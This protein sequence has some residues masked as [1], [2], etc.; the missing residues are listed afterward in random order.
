MGK[1]KDKIYESK[2]TKYLRSTVWTAIILSFFVPLIFDLQA[3]FPFAAPR[4]FF[5]MAMAQVAFFAWIVL[6]IKNKR[7]RPKIDLVTG[8]VGA[9]FIVLVLS[10]ILGADPFHSFWS[11][12]ERM[13]GLLTY[14]HLFAF[15]LV[16]SSIIKGEKDWMRLI[17]WITSIASIVSLISIAHRFGII[18]LSHYFQ[19]GSTLGNT[20]FMGS[21]LLV[22]IFFCLYAFF[23]SRDAWKI[24]YGTSFVIISSAI[25]LNPGGRAMKGALLAGTFLLFLLYFA[26]T[27]RSKIIQWA[28]RLLIISGI[29]L[30]L[31]IS[32]FAFVE[33]SIVREKIEDLRGMSARFVVWDIAWEGFKE[34]PVLGWGLENFPLVFQKE[35]NPELVVLDG[36]EVWFDRAHNIVFDSLVT[37]GLLGTLF[38]FLMFKA[39]LFV[40]WREY[41]KGKTDIWAPAIFTSLFVA[42]FIQNLTVFDMIS[43]FM[44]M[45]VMLAF[46]AS[47]KPKNEPSDN[48]ES[49]MRII[50]PGIFIIIT[51]ITLELFVLSSYRAN[52]SASLVLRA[53][54]EMTIDRYQEALKDPINKDATI[55]SISEKLIM[56]TTKDKLEGE[57]REATIEKMRFIIDKLEKNIASPPKIFKNYWI[58]GRMYNEYYNYRFLQELIKGD[59]SNKEEARE[60]VV[61]A[62]EILTM[63][64]EISPRRPEGYWELAQAKVNMGNIH[65]LFGE[66]D[67]AKERFNESFILVE[68]AV[69]LEPRDI[70]SQL[71][72]L[73]V[74]DEIIM[75]SELVKRKANEALEINPEWEEILKR[76]LDE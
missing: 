55:F 39:A 41:W 33:G 64:I 32:V 71:K 12:Y 14:I 13:S 16:L 54:V 26:F 53:P 23:K 68:K 9:F 75:D 2:G 74:A 69:A 59:F 7:Y 22:A 30:T 3:L 43:S 19:N 57:E 45:F 67:L 37:I 48:S 6:A 62:K 35:F 70:R 20:S 46:A 8:A 49:S 34:R 1:K 73:K 58:T 42:Y 65:I 63:A 25:L 18:E 24:F 72:M 52:L 31:F 28:A 50:I 4:A 17:G 38:F 51:I 56:N 10:T 27:E 15:F 40:F 44:L 11:N 21:Y 60:V 47:L 61:T 76:Y 36:G 5:F 29:G 66:P